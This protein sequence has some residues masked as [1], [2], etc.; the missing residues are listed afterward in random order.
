MEKIKYKIKADGYYTS[1]GCD[2]CEP[3]Y[4]ECYEVVGTE[5]SC[6]SLDHALMRILEQ[7]G[8]EVEVEY[9]EE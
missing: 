6:G 4:H 9:E 2:C 1:N 5:I 3:D 8:I 7:H